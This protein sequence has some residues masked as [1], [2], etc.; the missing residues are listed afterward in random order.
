MPITIDTRENPKD[1]TIEDA[2]PPPGVED[3]DA[4]SF[5]NSF[6]GKLEYINHLA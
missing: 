5:T 2:L 4:S 6:K 1:A 3:E